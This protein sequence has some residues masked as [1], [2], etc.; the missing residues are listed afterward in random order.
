VTDLSRVEQEAL[1]RYTNDAGNHV[2]VE[3]QPASGAA[4]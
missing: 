4:Q 1:A 2:A 3:V